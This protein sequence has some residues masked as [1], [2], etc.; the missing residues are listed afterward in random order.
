MEGFIPAFIVEHPLG[1]DGRNA[2]RK[3]RD[4]I[5]G[6]VFRESVCSC[7]LQKEHECDRAIL[8]EAADAIYVERTK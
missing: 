1:V 6:R 4:E 2:K 8:V 7:A 3:I 5:L